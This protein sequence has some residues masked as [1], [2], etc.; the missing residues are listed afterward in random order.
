MGQRVDESSL[1][2]LVGGATLT[3]GR[4]YARSGAV[5][6]RE[7]DEA[8][9][10][11]SGTVR[12][13]SAEPYEV[14]V[15]LR[16]AG[17]SGEVV[18][19]DGRCSCPVGFNCKHAVALLLAPE[20]A[21]PSAGG[22]P[23]LTL[24]QPAPQALPSGRPSGGSS[25]GGAPAAKA[26]RPGGRGGGGPGGP[27][28]GRGGS[29]VAAGDLGGSGEAAT[30]RRQAQAGWD[31]AFRALVAGAG[32][33][34]PAGGLAERVALQ[35]DFVPV[36]PVPRWQKAEPRP[37]VGL[38]PV[39]RSSS[40]NWVRT[41]VAWS[42]L[43]VLG[44]GASPAAAALPL[45]REMRALSTVGDS[46]SYGYGY[47]TGAEVLWLEDV[48]SRRVW[49]LLAE[50][51]EIGL[52]LVV[53]GKDARAVELAGRA[54]EVVVDLTRE[55]HGLVVAPE[56]RCG[57]EVIDAE[58]VVW[59]GS[60]PHGIGWWR[61]GAAAKQPPALVLAPLSP[62]F[63]PEMRDLLT[64]GAVEVPPKEA[65]RFEAELYPRLRRR[66][67]FAS[68]DGS[69][70]LAGAPDVLVARISFGEGPLVELSWSLLGGAG[71]AREIWDEPDETATAAIEA[72]GA[73]LAGIPGASEHTPWGPR[74]AP[75]LWMEGMDAVR[76]VAETLPRL[77]EIEAVVVEADD[78]L[79]AFR[80]ATDAPVVTFAGG[81]SDGGDWLDLTVSVEVG[82]EEVAFGELFVALA[83]GESHLVL[84]SGTYFSLDRPELHQLAE[85]IAEARS[86]QDAPPGG[87]RLGRFQ[88]SLWEELSALGTVTAQVGAWQEAVRA[89]LATAEAGE[90][91][92]G[93]AGAG[94]PALPLPTGLHATLRPYQETGFAWLASRF[95]HRLGGILADDM[96]LGKT[97][98]ALALICHAREEAG[99]DAPFLVVAPTSVV[100]N[101]ASEAAR[102]TPGLPTLAITETERRRGTSIAEAVGT[103]GAGLVVTSYT[104]FRLE[105][106]Q[107]EALEWAGLLLDEAQFAK[108]ASSHNY[109]RAR[110]LPAPFKLAMTGTPLENSLAELWSL[111]SIVAP[112]LFPRPDRFAEIYRTPIERKGDSERLDQLRRRIRPILL[113]RT[114]AEVASDL[115][116]KQEQV[117]ELDLH[118]RHRRRYQ[119]HLQRERQKILGLLGDMDG[120]RF[121]IFRSLTLLRQ[122]ALDVALVDPEGAGTP[123]TKLDALGEML[124]DVVA[125]GHR[126]LVFSQFT[127]FLGEARRRIEAA[128]IDCCYLDGKT[129]RRGEE[130]A[131][132]REGKAPVFLISL[133]AGGF[134]LNLT[135]ADY[136]ILLDP[137]W[138]PATE[139]QAVDRAHRIG[140]DR[141]VMVYRYV[142]RDTIEEKVMALKERKASLFDRVVGGGGFESGVLSAADVRELLA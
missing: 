30:S 117:L 22:R 20:P 138:N 45:L 94:P 69:V 38:R 100:G 70:E 35:F 83:Q 68:R 82:G 102:F 103:S 110:R 13:R 91:G 32:S 72:V 74:L 78:E 11:V 93:A 118:P 61:K 142:A 64:L 54:A 132:F 114:K 62:S 122:A 96:G 46:R 123:S 88:A 80:E 120:N 49:D 34:A 41:G 133:K 128:G 75:M 108:N 28:A 73:L 53:A 17:S 40:G 55:G 140:Q 89:L 57:A 135:E 65:E 50:A 67:S 29:G 47:G 39:L 79:P 59:I 137:W 112:G 26:G 107:Y 97:L 1:R 48:A 126:V 6:R 84:P 127:R 44:Y 90:E 130:I 37:G 99:V 63:A 81:E 12:G 23:N 129:R 85:L 2:R 36:R 119:A 4:G 105:Y 60:P 43:D 76:F 124:S 86:L 58:R 98:Q 19:L 125:D 10:E 27:A 21:G 3:R 131:R 101:W 141:K 134:G 18:S 109:Q 77:E 42:R 71:D 7:W 24:V 115:P 8:G 9:G 104:L 106:D 66:V 16:R 14:T 33:E 52:P 51:R 92:A 111:T 15:A 56:L 113:R 139:A 31:K 25:S 116:D 87:L 136:C 5:L 121:E 95:R